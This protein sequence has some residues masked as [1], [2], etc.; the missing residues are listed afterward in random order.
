MLKVEH[1][2]VQINL[3]FANALG[4]VFDKLQHDFDHIFLII[5]LVE[6][7]ESLQFDECFEVIVS[8]FEVDD[9]NEI[10]FCEDGFV[11]EWHEVQIL[12]DY[13]WL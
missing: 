12:I 8:L 1:D 5:I 7:I 13:F 3:S 10:I 4:I 11:L 2:I 6:V 9:L